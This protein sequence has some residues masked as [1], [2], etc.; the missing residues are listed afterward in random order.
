[1]QPANPEEYDALIQEGIKKFKQEMQKTWAMNVQLEE[2]KL[3]EDSA[4]LQLAR[5]LEEEDKKEAE[6]RRKE[7][8]ASNK[9]DCGICLD[10]IDSSDYLPL[11]RC[12]HMFHPGCMR[13]Y[14]KNEVIG[15]F[16]KRHRLTL[17][18]SH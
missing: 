2:V 10:V 7:I 9:V 16:T 11:D 5:A 14:L 6:K 3:K 4:S 13:I 17:D 1:M 15:N 18:I 8:E 12:G